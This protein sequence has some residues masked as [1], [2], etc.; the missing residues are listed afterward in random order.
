[1]SQFV[2]S[3]LPLSSNGLAAAAES[4]GVHVPEIWTVLEVETRSCGFLSTRQPEIL[5]ERHIFHRLTGGRYDDGDISDPTW[6]G[7]GAGGVA[8][9]QRLFRAMEK[10][11]KAALMSTSWGI[12]QIMGES[13]RDCEFDDVE[14]MVVSMCKSEDEQ[15]RAMVTYLLKSELHIPLRAHDWT[16]FARG[17]NGPDYHLNRYDLRLNGEYQKLVVGPLPDLQIRAAQLFL[18]Y[19]GF[20]PGPIDG[21]GGVRTLSSLRQF[22]AKDGAGQLNA[23][24]VSLVLPRLAAAIGHA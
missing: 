15:L 13:F 8:Q 2:G 10:D 16:S 14:T 18:L 6:G 23:T 12:G 20:H 17:Y 3:A 24:N 7:W 9:Y 5:F 22:V 21:L 4:L 1:M 11:R 19:L